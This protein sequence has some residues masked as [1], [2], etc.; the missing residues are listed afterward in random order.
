MNDLFEGPSVSHEDPDEA[1]LSRAQKRALR[2]ERRKA[3]VRRRRALVAVLVAIVIIGAGGYFVWTR[4][5]DF[6]SS[7]GGLGSGSDTEEV[8][9]F[10]GPGAG[11]QQVTVNAGDSGAAIGQTLEAA[12]VVASQQ[13]FVAAYNVNSAA[14][15]IQPGTYTLFK[16]MK[17]SDA[18]SALLD[19][20]KRSDYIVEIP[21][22]FRA[23]Q[24]V[25][26]IAKLTAVPE[27]DVLAAMADTAATG[28]PAEANGS[29]E[30]WLAPSQYQ[31]PLGTPP[32][33]MITEMVAKTVVTM[34][35]L[36][37]APG[38][39]R[40]VLLTKASLV[41]REAARAEDRPLVASVIENRLAIDMK[42]QFDSTVHYAFGGSEDATTTKEQ[43]ADPNLHNTYYHKGL[44]VGPIASPGLESL[45]AAL[46]PADTDYI[47]FVTINLDTGETRFA[48]T[49]PEHDKN[50]ELY[51]D[52]IDENSSE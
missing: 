43:R 3:A 25:A 52:W 19:V 9:D 11:E 21:N 44:P 16:E 49:K 45:Q 32:V 12:G 38:A 33:E 7:L 40:Q 8:A 17:A 14:A 34:D 27:A 42:L 1:S 41:E 10:P 30:G 51:Y 13:A 29:Y 20:T 36:G 35:E 2:E 6:F 50:A 46:N 15:G 37:V 47:F 39:E 22:G 31:F 5:V 48:E 23:E 28:L 18:V 26:R 4:G 24:V